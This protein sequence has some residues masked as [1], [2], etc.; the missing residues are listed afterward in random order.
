M[1][2]MLV[3]VPSRNR[4]E[5]VAR[6]CDALSRTDSNV[7]LIVGID[8][9]D[10]YIDEYKALSVQWGDPFLLRIG[11]RKRFGPMLNELGMPRVDAYKYFMFCGDDHVP[12]TLHWDLEYRQVL[13]DIGS[14]VVYGNDLVMGEAIA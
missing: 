11:P 10:S 9:D 3:M 2:E 1:R 7:D 14:G 12:T 5:N 4:P 8:D 13:R 6:L